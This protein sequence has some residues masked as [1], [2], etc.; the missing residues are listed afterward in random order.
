MVLQPL[1]FK[2]LQQSSLCYVPPVLSPPR[3]YVRPHEILLWFWGLWKELSAMA[4]LS[5]GSSY[6]PAAKWLAGIS[7]CWVQLFPLTLA[8]WV[9]S[10]HLFGV[11]EVC[12]LVVQLHESLP[13]DSAPL[14]LLLVLPI[15]WGGYDVYSNPTE[16]CPLCCLITESHLAT[17]HMREL[18][19][20]FCVS[21][22]P[23]KSSGN[24]RKQKYGNSSG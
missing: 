2:L 3:W 21:L 1:P 20:N 14:Q 5:S 7:F 16:W 12:S 11:W 9:L 17:K 4:P 15:P 13:V 6:V 23:V 19:D 10:L 24:S 22:K 18:L 8:A